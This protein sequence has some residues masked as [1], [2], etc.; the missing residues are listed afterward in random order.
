[1]ASAVLV[2]HLGKRFGDLT[3]IDDVSLDVAEGSIFGLIGPNGAGKTTTLECLLG[4]TAP[5]RGEIRIKGLDPRTDPHP[6][7]E[8]LGALLQDS[9]L[10][11]AMTAREALRLCSRFYERPAE[12]EALLATFHLAD[13]ADAAYRTLSGGQKQ[14]LSLAMAFINRPSVVVLDEPTA[15]LDTASREELHRLIRNQRDLGTTIVFTT[16]YLEEARGL[17]DQV[18][19]MARGRVIAMDSPEALVARSGVPTRIT[20]RVSPGLALP[21]VS[22]LRGLFEVRVEKAPR[23]QSAWS[24]LTHT[25]TQAVKA[26]IDWVEKSGGSLIDLQIRRPTLDDAFNQLV[27]RGSDGADSRA[28]S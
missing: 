6:V 11:D 17:C 28:P 5:D 10:P 2:S 26:L 24:C 14:A 21:E 23:D 13:K 4:L 1:M 18:A 9:A 15:G 12:P 7:K 22:G 19:F 20:L 27:A 3:A 8:T 25:P 16:H